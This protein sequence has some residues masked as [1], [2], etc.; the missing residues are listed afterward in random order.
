MYRGSMYL[1]VSWLK[2]MVVVDSLLLKLLGMVYQTGFDLL[3]R[4][5]SQHGVPHGFFFG[6]LRKIDDGID[7]RGRGGETK[8]IVAQTA[9][10]TQMSQ[11]LHGSLRLAVH[12]E[13][14]DVR[15]SDLHTS[16]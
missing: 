8:T 11:T 12:R 9:I 7:R 16:E 6:I 15:R 1:I 4:K 5:C 10:V 3:Q 13:A 2:G 14:C